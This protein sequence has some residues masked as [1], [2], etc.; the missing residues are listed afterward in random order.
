MTLFGKNNSDLDAVKLLGVLDLNLGQLP[1][2]LGVLHLVDGL[3]LP[4]LERG[5]NASSN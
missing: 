4:R 3:A 2:E 1:I 5:L